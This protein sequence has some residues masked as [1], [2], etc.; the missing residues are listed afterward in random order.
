MKWKKIYEISTYQFRGEECINRVPR[1]FYMAG[2][3]EEMYD[4]KQDL[5]GKCYSY[6]SGVGLSGSLMTECESMVIWNQMYIDLDGELC[7]EK[8]EVV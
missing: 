4:A 3:P 7:I 8:W 2:C 6:F 1:Y 5:Y